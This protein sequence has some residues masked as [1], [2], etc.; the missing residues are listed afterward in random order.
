[1]SDYL[2][3]SGVGFVIYNPDDFKNDKSYKALKDTEYGYDQIGTK[4]TIEAMMRIAKEWNALHPDR[5]LQYGDISR[6][7]GI[8]TPDHGTHNNGK[9]FDVRPLRN[10]SQTGN[11]AKLTYGDPTYDR[12]LTKEF[13]LL[14][15][16]LYPGTKFYFNDKKIW[17]DRE[18][19]SFVERRGGHDNHLHVI[20][21][22]GN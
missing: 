22:G 17:E 1:M 9:V 13:I 6:P 2:P 20:F 19:N 16:K 15:R 11:A 8:N 5:L 7:G 18:F 4:E 10:D 21:P 12:N 14:V 3:V